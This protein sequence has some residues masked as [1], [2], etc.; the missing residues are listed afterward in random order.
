MKI[1]GILVIRC[2]LGALYAWW[3]Y[4]YLIPLV[5]RVYF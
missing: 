4:A 5:R 3:M 2:V 1:H